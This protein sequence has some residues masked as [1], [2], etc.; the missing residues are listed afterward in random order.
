MKRSNLVFFTGP[1]PGIASGSAQTRAIQTPDEMA[2]KPGF[3]RGEIVRPEL[4]E[5]LDREPA[6]V[7]AGSFPRSAGELADR[8]LT[9]EFLDLHAPASPFRARSPDASVDEVFSGIVL[10]VK[11][12]DEAKNVSRAPAGKGACDRQAALKG[13]KFVPEKYCIADCN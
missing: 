12:T 13:R 4:R 3:D 2:R 5:G 10:N 9:G 6:G 7:E 1:L 11:E 8:P